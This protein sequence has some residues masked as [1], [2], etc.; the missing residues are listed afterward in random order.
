MVKMKPR[1]AEGTLRVLPTLEGEPLK[2]ERIVVT[3]RDG[4]RVVVVADALARGEWC[5][6]IP[7]AKLWS[8]RSPSLYGHHH[9]VV[10][11]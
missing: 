10:R 1:I 7:D 3:V 8:P 5:A 11:W 6:D 4:D 9:G 2:A